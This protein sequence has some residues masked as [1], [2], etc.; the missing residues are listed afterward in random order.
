MPDRLSRRC[1]FVSSFAFQPNSK[2][3]GGHRRAMQIRELVSTLDGFKISSLEHSLETISKPKR[4]AS[5]LRGLP[6][7]A[8]QCGVSSRSAI[9][10]WYRLQRSRESLKEISSNSAIKALLWEDTM[11]VAPHKAAINKYPIVALP[12]NIESFV[13]PSS[14]GIRLDAF[15]SLD[16]L[17]K[18]ISLLS[19]CESVFTI[20]PYDSWLLAN[21]GIQSFVLPYWPPKPIEIDC[22]RLRSIRLGH[23]SWVEKP[24][25]LVLGTIGNPPT[26]DGMRRLLE[27]ISPGLV[28]A[29]FQVVVAGYG[30]EVLAQYIHTLPNVSI[31]GSVT[32]LRLMELLSTCSCVVINQDYGTG[33]LT[34][35]PELLLSGVSIYSNCIAARGYETLNGLHIFDDFDSLLALLI[36][37]PHQIPSIPTRNFQLERIFLDRLVSI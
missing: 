19:E 26:L 37:V 23:D 30:T 7:S 16:L 8:I 29:S 21:L 13:T 2:G 22:L 1:C 24:T 35:I 6:F 9:N 10:N 3:H 17:I 12:H 11:N 14:R 33:A 20:S 18:E 34:K 32:N 15:R 4:L 5:Y 28:S 25:A 36:N 31:E 27:G